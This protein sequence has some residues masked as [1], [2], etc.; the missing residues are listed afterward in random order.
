MHSWILFEGYLG[1]LQARFF[2]SPASL[3]S[4]ERYGGSISLL[5]IHQTMDM[6]EDHGKHRQRAHLQE[7][8]MRHSET[9]PSMVY[10]T[11]EDLLFGPLEAVSF[12]KLSLAAGHASGITPC[13]CASYSKVNVL[14]TLKDHRPCFLF[15][16]ASLARYERY[17]G[18]ASLLG[19][20]QTMDVAEDHGKHRQRAH[21]QKVSTC[22]GHAAEILC[23]CRLTLTQRELHWQNATIGSSSTKE[24]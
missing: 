11:N 9:Y 16:A 22:Q 2:F 18:Y 8:S 4:Y 7:A 21:I 5:G 20:H 14:L 12:D 6:A 1:R 15:I 10:A 13:E 19:I 3:A 17:G 24:A 23:Q